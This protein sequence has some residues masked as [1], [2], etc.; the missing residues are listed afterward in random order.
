MQQLEIGV[1]YVP[2]STQYNQLNTKFAYKKYFLDVVKFQ[3]W[4]DSLILNKLNAI[5]WY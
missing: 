1:F 5:N 4:F 2:I 3:I